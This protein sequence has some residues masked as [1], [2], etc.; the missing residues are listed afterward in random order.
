MVKYAVTKQ[1]HPSHE[2]Q[3]VRLR[4][5]ENNNVPCV[6]FTDNPQH[7]PE[8][9]DEGQ[10]V[11]Q[12]TIE[13][14][15]HKILSVEK[16]RD[17]MAET[18]QTK[19]EKKLEQSKAHLEEQRLN[20]EQQRDIYTKQKEEQFEEMRELIKKQN[21]E[22]KDIHEYSKRLHAHLQQKEPNFD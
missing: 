2:C 16:S 21:E 13:S 17:D 12:N 14:L 3:K 20:F 6:S 15:H 1:L 9:A 18:L 19:I 8:D 5:E 7:Y 22:I 4:K 11:L 10:E